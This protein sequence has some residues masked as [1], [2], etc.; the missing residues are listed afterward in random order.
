MQHYDIPVWEGQ[1]RVPVETGLG[2]GEEQELMELADT[3]R[4]SVKEWARSARTTRTRDTR[5]KLSL[6]HERSWLDEPTS[7]DVTVPVRARF[8]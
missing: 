5:R 1:V 2:K 4:K 6:V 8:E 7:P 3:S